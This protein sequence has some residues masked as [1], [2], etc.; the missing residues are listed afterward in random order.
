M[1]VYNEEWLK[2]NIK[3]IL[4]VYLLFEKLQAFR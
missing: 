3:I 4:N 2:N 1:G